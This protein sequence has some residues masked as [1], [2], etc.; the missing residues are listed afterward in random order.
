M[1]KHLPR[2]IYDVL[3]VLHAGRI[4]AVAA[5]FKI[6]IKIH[7]SSISN[8][9]FKIHIVLDPYFHIYLWIPV[10]IHTY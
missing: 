5:H 6:T 1:T 2:S 8:F 9:I 4:L 3:I 7:I 10:P